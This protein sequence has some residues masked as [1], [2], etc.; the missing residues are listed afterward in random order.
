MKR[1]RTLQEGDRVLIRG[2]HPWAGHTGTVLGWET[3]SLLGR[4]APKIQLDCGPEV[5]VT[6]SSQLKKVGDSA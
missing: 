5:F 6:H 2:D 4:Q 1:K 3:L